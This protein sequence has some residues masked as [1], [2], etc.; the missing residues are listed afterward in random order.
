MSKLLNKPF[1]A[2]TLYAL[3]LLVCCVP[4][5]YWVVDYIWLEE[6]DDHNQTIKQQIIDGFAHTH[7]DDEQLNSFLKIW[8]TI[9]PGTTITPV[10]DA[11]PKPD[12][13]YTITRQ[14][15]NTTG[16]EVE[17]F[18]GLWAHI[19][20]NNK[21]YLLTIETNVEETDETLLAIAVITFLFFVFLVVGFII[22]NKKIA[23]KIWQP[24]RDTLEKLKV[25]DLTKHQTQQFE[26][27]DIEEFEELNT[28]LSKLIA[29][30]IE[31]FYQQ[32]T[33]IEN[34]SHELQ[35]PLALLKSKIDVLLQNKELTDEQWQIITGIN[36]S[37]LR[38]TRIN[39]NLLLLAKIENKQF[40]DSEPIELSAIIKESTN[41]LEDYITQ[42][43]LSLQININQQLIIN[44][45]HTLVEIL[46]NN[47]LINAIQHNTPNGEISVALN[48]NILSI[49]N[50]GAATLNAENIFKRFS[51]SSSQT[52]NS[53]L[54]LAIVK[55]VCNRYNWQITYTYN[56]GQH[57]FSVK[58]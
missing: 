39:K 49:G 57:C 38:V 26:K 1:K 2:F 4:V 28:E 40:N 7:T 50:S 14:I 37:L 17:R 58:F 8:N 12:S 55:E 34:A 20:I 3:A 22:I 30:S 11:H 13:I 18:R 51:Q 48:N 19:T 56:N 15:S 53:G 36:S 52:A 44:C 29:R 9:E 42:K 5:Y 45:N 27:T 6:L 25:F 47:L 24:F 31:A 16:V 35:T 10:D 32:K 23:R 46:V 41:S 43:G 33:F 54:G 21:L